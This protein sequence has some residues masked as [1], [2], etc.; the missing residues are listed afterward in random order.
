MSNSRN[1]IIAAAVFL[2]LGLGPARAERLRISP[3]DL[4]LRVA[5]SEQ[6]SASLRQ[7][8]REMARST[9][10]PVE[11]GL[12]QTEQLLVERF[13]ERG[14]NEPTSTLVRY[15]F[16]VARLDQSQKF[17]EEFLRRDKVMR[18]GVEYLN[19]YIEAIN[20]VV[21][22]APYLQTPPLSAPV[23]QEFPLPSVEKSEDGGILVRRKFPAP[24]R[25]LGRENLRLL[26]DLA[27]QEKSEL[28]RRLQQL[29]QAER[30]FLDEVALLGEE[31]IEMRP[32]VRRWVKVP[33]E[34]LPFSL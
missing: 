23:V 16:I 32:R 31:L 17:S 2:A 15:Y 18:T 19:G 33:G 21:S 27:H 7:E 8:L 34:G 6:L 20:K 25:S 1:V 11:N 5:V 9:P 13:R 28:E 4:R 3:D 30:T 10:L 26:R 22:Q 12:V 29:A 14:W 24:A